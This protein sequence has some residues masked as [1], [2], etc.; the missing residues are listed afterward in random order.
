[1]V[2]IISKSPGYIAQ[3]KKHHKVPHVRDAHKINE[4]FHVRAKLFRQRKKFLGIRFFFY[5]ALY[6]SLISSITS[7]FNVFPLI[8]KFLDFLL[9]YL[10]ILGTT[11]S[12]AV[13]V[14][15]TYTIR[16]YD[17][18]I[19]TLDAHILAIHVK[20]DNSDKKSFDALLKKIK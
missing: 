8:S 1:M 15:L 10:G 19:A 16:V 6:A 2:R 5:I 9:T 17:R 4:L 7:I 13:I 18:D 12:L 11:I 3:I 20:H 14:A